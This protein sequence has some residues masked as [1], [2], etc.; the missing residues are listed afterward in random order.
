MDCRCSSSAD[1]IRILLVP[2]CSNDTRPQLDFNQAQQTEQRARRNQLA[3]RT[4]LSVCYG[5]AS[6]S[7]SSLSLARSKEPSGDTQKTRHLPRE[8]KLS[9]LDVLSRENL[10]RYEFK[11]SVYLSA[12]KV[13]DQK[14]HRIEGWVI[15]RKITLP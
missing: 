13:Y 14:V 4:A 12:G 10:S 15:N 11:V 8:A 1:C 5:I 2:P 6:F 7:S 9:R 3:A